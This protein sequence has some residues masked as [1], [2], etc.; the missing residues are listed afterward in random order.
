[1]WHGPTAVE[2]HVFKLGIHLVGGIDWLLGVRDSSTRTDGGDDEQLFLADR[3][4]P[5]IAL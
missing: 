4:D 5:V 2:G 3:L 1:V